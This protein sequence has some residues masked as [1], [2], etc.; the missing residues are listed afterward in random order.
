MASEPHV[1]YMY[2]SYYITNP[3]HGGK[4]TCRICSKF[5]LGD[6]HGMANSNFRRVVLGVGDV[7]Y[8]CKEHDERQTP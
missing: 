4:E 3:A 1:T 5:V 7:S 8:F 6:K 2:F